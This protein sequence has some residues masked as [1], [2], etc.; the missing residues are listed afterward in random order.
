MR[1]LPLP[2][3]VANDGTI[4]GIKSIES[5]N[6]VSAEE[7]QFLDKIRDDQRVA[8]RTVSG[9]EYTISL[10]HQKNVLGGKISIPESLSDIEELVFGSWYQYQQT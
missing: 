4:I 2:I 10:R 8:I 6:F 1:H 3:L 9:F 5:M 7:D